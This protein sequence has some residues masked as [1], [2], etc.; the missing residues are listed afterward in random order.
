MDEDVRM[1]RAA[2]GLV[3]DTVGQVRYE[4]LAAFQVATRVVNR[5]TSEPLLVSFMS[6]FR[7]RRVN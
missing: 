3:V 4:H 2:V 6:H 1:V 5:C 7:A